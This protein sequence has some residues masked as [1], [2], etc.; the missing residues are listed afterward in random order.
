MMFSCV[1][2]DI[3][4][5]KKAQLL[6]QQLYDMVNHDLRSPLTFISGL[7]YL[8]GNNTLLMLEKRPLLEALS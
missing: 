8:L 5:I 7:L 1:I 2:H 6:K 3:D 4:D